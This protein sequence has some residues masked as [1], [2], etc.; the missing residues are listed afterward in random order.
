[1]VKC[2]Y[3]RC[4]KYIG[5]LYIYIDKFNFDMVGIFFL[6]IYRVYRGVNY[7]D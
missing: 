5:I 4:I 7:Y 2:I 6:L 1:M 3:I